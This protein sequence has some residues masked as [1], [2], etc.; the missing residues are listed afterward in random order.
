MPEALYDQD[1]HRNGKFIHTTIGYIKDRHMLTAIAV[2]SMVL[3][4]L[5][6]LPHFLLPMTNDDRMILDGEWDI[7][8]FPDKSPL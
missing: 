1:C 3:D 4:V 7:I 8:H 2:S 5:S 6:Y